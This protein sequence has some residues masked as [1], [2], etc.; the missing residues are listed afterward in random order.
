MEKTDLS[1]DYQNPKGK[2]GLTAHFSEIIELKLG[3]QVPYILCILTL[4][5]ELWL[6]SNYL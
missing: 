1:K 4:F 3:E 5:S 2:I 6:L